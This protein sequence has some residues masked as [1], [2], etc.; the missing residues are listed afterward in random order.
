MLNLFCYILMN[1]NVLDTGWWNFYG[2]YQSRNYFTLNLSFYKFTRMSVSTAKMPLSCRLLRNA[3]K[4]Y[5]RAKWNRHPHTCTKTEYVLGHVEGILAFSKCAM[6]MTANNGLAGE[7][8]IKKGILSTKFN[9]KFTK[10]SIFLY[11]EF[12]L[13]WILTLLDLRHSIL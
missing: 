1:G 13:Q 2:S 7:S 6:K 5:N 4:K 3:R 8:I 11:I 12:I 9:I 10:Y